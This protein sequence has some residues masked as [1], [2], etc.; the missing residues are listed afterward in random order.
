MGWIKSIVGVKGPEKAAAA[1]GK[2]RNKWT[3]LWRSSSSASS[4]AGSGEG[5]SALASQASSDSFSSVVAAVV[6]APPRDFRLIRQEW[7]AVRIQTAFRAFLARRALK[8]LRG[9][10]RLQ[11]I[12]RGRFV[13]RQLAVTVKCMNALLRVQERARERRA[14]SSADGRG[15]QD[16]RNG[17]TNP[18]K[19]AEEQWCDRQGSVDEVRS[20]LHKKNEGAAKRERAIAYALSHQVYVVA[21]SFLFRHCLPYADHHPFQPRNSKHNSRPSSPARCVR[22]HES[23]K[24]SQNM[25]YLEGWRSTKPW[26]TRI[27]DP[28]HSDSQFLKNSEENLTV[29]KNS[30]A[31]SVR[32][33]RNNVTT[34]VVA[35]PPSVLSASSSDFV[36]EG[37]SPSTSSV[38]P[39]SAA[40]VLASEARSDGGHVGGPNYMNL[41]KSAK[42][43]L[44]GFSSHRGS[45]QLQRQ[46]RSGDMPRKALS[47]IDTQSN[48]GSE[49]SVTSRRLNSMSLKGCSMTRSLDKE[50]DC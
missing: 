33:R 37:S 21:I 46:Q 11:A 30:D 26:E 47:S 25:N 22:S 28:N 6:R 45:F 12:V 17:R 24:C 48:A 16:D 2:G 43:R 3:R 5:G 32:I 9:I 13:R 10:V 20:K 19:D 39:V 41:T 1:G 8:A 27:M 44:N 14:R 42:A 29:A 4:R 50:N 49:I 36:C 18:D 23:L 31:G 38:T 7:A 40:S 15:S 35:T 34:R